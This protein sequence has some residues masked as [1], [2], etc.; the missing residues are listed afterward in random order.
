MLHIDIDHMMAY[1]NHMTEYNNHMTY[2]STV[3]TGVILYNMSGGST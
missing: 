3:L 1:N 2:H